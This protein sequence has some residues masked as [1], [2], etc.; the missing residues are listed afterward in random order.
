MGY[1]SV[2][3]AFCDLCH[4]DGVHLASEKLTWNNQKI[5]LDICDEC[6]NRVT[7]TIDEIPGM[8]EHLFRNPP[9]LA[10]YKAAEGVNLTDVRDWAYAQGIEVSKRGRISAGIIEQYK[11]ATGQ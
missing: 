1:K 11:T 9:K 7:W 5:S 4:R 2:T 3:V 10:A 8:R 6:H